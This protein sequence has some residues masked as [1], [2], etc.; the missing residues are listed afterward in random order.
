MPRLV[1][2]P[3]L[4]ALRMPK[5]FSGGHRGYAF[6]EY[7]LPHEAEEA[8]LRLASTHLYGR[9]L[10]CSWATTEEADGE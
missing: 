4:R 3:K 9:H 6:V 2:C 1:D 7:V 10:V 8:N 5:K